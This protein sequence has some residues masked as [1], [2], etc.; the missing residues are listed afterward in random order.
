MHSK[1]TIYIYG[2]NFR[3][4]INFLSGDMMTLKGHGSYFANNDDKRMIIYPFFSFVLLNGFNFFKV[5]RER[6][7]IIKYEKV[8]YEI[9]QSLKR[10]KCR[11][12]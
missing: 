7:E 10:L 2:Q 4:E 1:Y 11:V 5:L 12:S 8:T 6:K 9:F 3:L